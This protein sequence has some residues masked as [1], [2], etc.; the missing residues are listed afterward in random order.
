[1]PKKKPAKKKVKKASPK[2]S[3]VHK[4]KKSKRKLVHKKMPFR[5]NLQGKP[6]KHIQP[7]H[8]EPKVEEKTQIE[9]V[10]KP[11]SSTYTAKHIQ[12]L[13]GLE[14]V[15]KRPAMYIG[16]TDEAGL[17]ESLREIIDNAVDEALA[18]YAKNIWIT[19][20]EDGSATV[21][22]DGRGI[23]IDV[24]PQYKKSALEIVMT[25]LH[26]GG[27]FGGS[28]YKI[29]GGLHGVGASVVNALSEWLVAEV[30][31]KGK[32]H[33]QEY[34]RGVPTTKIEQNEKSKL[35]LFN[36]LE[37]GT[38]ITFL[39]DSQVFSTIKFNFETIKKAVR[40][41]AY[42]VPNLFFHLV[43]KS[44]KEEKRI[45][46]Y[47]EGGIVSLVEK[48]NENKNPIH[49]VIFVKKSEG[50]I[51]VETSLQ[52]NDVYTESVESYVNVIHTVNGGTHL[53]GFRMAL[54]RAIND[55]GKKI[56][57]FKEEEDSI[58]GDDTKEG[59]TA[60]VFIKMP[61]D[62]IQFEGQTKGKL[63]N[64]EIQP[65]VY[66]VVKDSLS[67]Y[68][69]EN[70]GTARKILEKVYLAAKA[71][72][73]AKAAKEAILRKGALEGSS[74]PG[75]LADCQEKDPNISELY[76]VEGDSAGGSAKQGRDRKF[77][78]ILPLKGKILNTER[79]RLDKIIEHEEVKNLIIALGAGIGETVNF[80]KLR[81]KR[82]IIMTDADVDGQHIETLILTFF[83]RHLPEI[84]RQGYLYI[85]QPPL[86]KITIGKDSSYVYSDEQKDELLKTN[87]TEQKITIQRYKGLGEMNPDQLW[88]T[89]MNPVNRILK[90]VRIDDAEVADAT[91]TMLMGDEVPPRKHF[92]QSNAKT[93]TLDI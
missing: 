28:A 62:R 90:Q 43:D 92:I 63:G 15:R 30:K 4:I 7:K 33:K 1:M 91:F 5:V 41:R 85:A 77:Q 46:F 55:Y 32:I 50:D 67:T 74:L 29:S 71:R 26:A 48:L 65:L 12:V 79:A 18:G 13:E 66:T 24:M 37:S 22:D 69:E 27:K 89:T 20:N 82:I 80:D 19:L 72:L 3:K 75:K 6:K 83:F 51:E 57:S 45:N 88:E 56:G 25:K 49:E 36:N 35:D 40:E 93:A 78:A 68:F 54:T 31:R 11:Q 87:K 59:L 76:L 44:E 53:T 21:I 16:S 34:K 8:T 10:L 2:K 84:I 60:V 17:H 9:P 14:P 86:Y 23:P 58:T 64:A 73:A 81:Y 70:P 39:P 61:Q 52:Y 42:L 38:A 47:F